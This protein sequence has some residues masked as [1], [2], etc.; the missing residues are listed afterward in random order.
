MT[1][2]YKGAFE[3]CRWCNG[4][5]CNQCNLERKKYEDQF[6]TP[7]PLFSADVNDPEDME[8]LKEVFGR[9]ALEHAFGPDGGGMLYHGWPV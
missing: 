4:Q 8:L 5:G 1:T 9:Q 3:H 2:F 6:K 7:Q